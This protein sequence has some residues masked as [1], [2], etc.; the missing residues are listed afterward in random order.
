MHF[1]QTLIATA[2]G[3][4]IGFGGTSWISRRE[5]KTARKAEMRQALGWFLGAASIAV[6]QLSH[7]ASCSG[8][9]IGHVDLR[10]PG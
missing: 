3:A 1:W 8:E 10:Q 6:A 7:P 4:A 9:L 2:V 5:R